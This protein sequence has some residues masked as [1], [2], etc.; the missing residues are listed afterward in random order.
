[1]RAARERP[2][3]GTVAKQKTIES[4]AHTVASALVQPMALYEKEDTCHTSYEEED[5]CSTLV[6]PMALLGV[7]SMRV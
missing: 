3:M 7:A 5:T 6:R 2:P 1:M 4:E